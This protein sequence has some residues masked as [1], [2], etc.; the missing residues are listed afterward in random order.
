MPSSAAISAHR[1][2]KLPQEA[3]STRSPGPG[4]VDDGRGHRPAARRGEDQHLAL[5]LEDA[6]QALGDV[7]PEGVNSSERGYRIGR[8][9]AA[10]TRA[11]SGRRARAS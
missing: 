3:T 2:P 6:A 8:A 11:G 5:G 10:T 1:S 4:Q 7:L 9:P